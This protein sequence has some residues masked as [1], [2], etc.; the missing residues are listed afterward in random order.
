MKNLKNI[1]VNQSIADARAIIKSN[2]A[3][4]ASTK[5]V[6]TLLI[7]IIELFMNKFG[8]NCKNSGVPPAQ[9]P[10]REKKKREQSGRKPGAQMGHKGTTLLKTDNPDEIVYIPLDFETLPKGRKYT[11]LPDDIRQVFDIVIRLHVTEY[12]VQCYRD[13]FGNIFRGDCPYGVNSPVQYGPSLRG[14]VCYLTHYQMMPIE[15]M[16]NFFET[17]AGLGI[18]AGT[19]VNI[20]TEASLALEYFAILAKQELIASSVLHADETGIN[21]AGKNAWI[22]NGS[23]IHWSLF[24]VSDSRGNIAMDSIGILSNFKGVLV[25]DHWK[26]YFKYGCIHAMC[27]AHLV[28][29]LTRVIEE[30]GDKWATEMVKHLYDMKEQVES[31]TD[32]LNDQKILEL[33]EI[34]DA[35]LTKGEF[36]CPE[37]IASDSPKRGRVKQSRARNL[38]LRLR[39]YK[40]A[41]LRFMTHGDAPFTNNQAERDIRM[42]KVQQKISGCYKTLETAS[43]SCLVKSF[44]STCGKQGICVSTALKELFEGKLPKFLQH[45]SSDPPVTLQEYRIFKLTSD[46]S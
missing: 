25:H 30:T 46:P 8:A 2:K 38:W 10:N 20:N 17:Q 28:R 33:T 42:T 37:A 27:G 19:I 5:T 12:Q 39:D 29:E 6:M 45:P 7:M 34:Y 22:H 15:R 4:D 18:S 3:L 43:A 9:D 32:K 40:A 23:T 13:Q 44:I 16:V 1:N 41:T 26:S 21:I 24:S 11:A 31:S 36:E 14:L 35:I